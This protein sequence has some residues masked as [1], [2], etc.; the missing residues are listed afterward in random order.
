MRARISQN[1][2]YHTLA[3]NNISRD[4]IS[5]EHLESYDDR[6]KELIKIHSELSEKLPEL[7]DKYINVNNLKNR[8]V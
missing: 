6:V 3:H 4:H 1:S 5:S 2:L 8:H 7:M